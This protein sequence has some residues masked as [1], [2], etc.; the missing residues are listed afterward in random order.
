MG[1]ATADAL[2]GALAAFGLTAL[3]TFLT[4][5]S[6]LLRLFGGLFLFYLAYTSL[7]AKPAAMTTCEDSSPRM[8]LLSAYATTFVLTL[9]NPMTI[10]AFLGIFAGLGVGSGDTLASVLTVVG[11]FAGSAMWWLLLTLGVSLLRGR[12]D[13]RWMRA[14]NIVSGLMIGAFAVM[15]WVGH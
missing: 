5:I 11:V 14:V 4:D 12:F 1:A 15:I 13:A 6:P 3:T 2:Y 8:G 10:F 9:T 7:R